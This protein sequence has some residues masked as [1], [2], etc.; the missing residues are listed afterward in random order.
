MLEIKNIEKIFPG[1][2]KA[3]DGISFKVENGEIFGF[4]GPNGAGKST[5]IK[6]ITGILKPTSG[7]IFFN[8]KNISENPT[9]TKKKIG[10]VADEPIIMEKLTGME[11]LNFISD[12]FEVPF[13]LRKERIENLTKD[14]KIF[15]SL[16]NPVSSYSHGMKQKLSLVS[17][18]L[19]NPELWILDEPIVGLDPESAFI[20]KKMMLSHAEKGFSVF[21]S[22]HIMEIAEKIC[23]RIAIINSGKIIFIG[24]VEELKIQ[25]GEKSLEKVFLEVTD[26]EFEKTNFSYLD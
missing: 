16:K 15:D 5:T 17:T 3:V 12:I 23:D 11:Y 7:N 2:K 10:Y 8:G 1:N 9:D 18:L 6:M 21:F 24:T 22:T 13:A 19:H 14:F 25:K 4:L 20:L 26:S